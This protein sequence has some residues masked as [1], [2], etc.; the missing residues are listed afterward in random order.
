M[1][2]VGKIARRSF[3]VGSAA[4]VGGVAFGV[5]YLNAPSENTL[6]AGKGETVLIPYVFID[7][8]GITIITPRAEM[9]QGV[10]TT[11]ASLVA[12]E[13]DVD[14]EDITTL[15][16]PP[17]QAYYNTAFAGA[18]LPIKEYEKSDFM[19]GVSAQLGKLGKV[20]S[21]QITG[22]STSMVDGYKKMRHAGASA[23]ETL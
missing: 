15:H 17:A 22:G 3:L 12:E 18:I 19:H 20:G 1:A 11:L 16:G 13:M 10:H 4:I 14:L 9:G 23:R 8:N 7:A 5:Y 6:K 2:S 21:L